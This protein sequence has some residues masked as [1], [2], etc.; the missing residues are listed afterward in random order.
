M[1]ELLPLA[2]I[3]VLVLLSRRSDR[4]GSAL[5]RLGRLLVWLGVVIGLLILAIG[6]VTVLRQA[7]WVGR[8]AVLAAVTAGEVLWQLRLR[9]ARRAPRQVAR[10]DRVVFVSMYAVYASAAVGWLLLGLVPALAAAIPSF[11]DQLRDW[12]R[13]GGVFA[14]MSLQSAR[15]ARNASSGVQVTLD[16]L[17]STLNLALATFLVVKVRGNRTANL[18]ALGMIGTAVAFNL[19][20]HSALLIIGDHLGELTGLF[21][22]LGIHVLAGIAYVFALLLFPDGAV[23]RSRGP[24]LM[25]L[26]LVFGMISFIAIPDHTSALVLLFGVLVPAAALVAQSRRF[27]DAQSPELR[28][29]FRLL[30][31]AMG[32]SLAGALAVL[33]VTGLLNSRDERFSETTRDYELVAPAVGTYVFYCDPH[34]EDMRGEVIV[35]E[36]D[37]GEAGLDS[38]P[39]VRITARGNEFDKDRIE[40]VAGSTSVIRFTNTDGTAHNV[41]IYRD[42]GRRDEVFVGQ[43][44]SG[45]DLA[46]FTFRVFRFVFAVIPVALFVAILRFHLWD[47][48]RLVNR[49]MVYSALTGVLGLV[50][51]AGALVVG[52]V[53]GRVFNQGELVAVWILLAAMLIRPARRRLQTAI[54]KRFY[55]EKLDT[56]R[57]LESFAAHVRDQIDLDMLADELVSVVSTTMHPEQVSLWLRDGEGSAGATDGSADR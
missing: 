18:L 2:A 57:T 3:A 20:S 54:D 6:L 24:H 38:V 49:A 5:R 29:L 27:R 4:I 46:T 53:P 30:R 37:N 31:A 41:S 8:A 26:A 33:T 44:F 35:R 13:G 10:I 36:P 22:D 19:Q 50:Y 48:D 47:V 1:F 7:S 32:L 23:D 56:I 51:A 52:L 40:L 12:G 17:F 11:A 45:Q 9:T 34:I 15:A 25:A 16:Y 14:D 42:A 55:R 28:Q 21:H 43:L 39:V